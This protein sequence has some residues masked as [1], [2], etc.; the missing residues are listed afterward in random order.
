MVNAGCSALLHQRSIQAVHHHTPS[1]QLL[2]KEPTNSISAMQCG[3]ACCSVVQ[4]VAVWCSVLHCG[5]ACCSVAQRVV[6][7]SS[8]M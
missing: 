3:A 8:V 7:C 5:T 6:A 2:T 4:R 1:S